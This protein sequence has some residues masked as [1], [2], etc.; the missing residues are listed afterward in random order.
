MVKRS[1]MNF[2]LSLGVKTSRGRRE[3]GVSQLAG[4]QGNP[5]TQ[6]LTPDSQGISQENLYSQ[7]NHLRQGAHHVQGGELGV[8]KELCRWRVMAFPPQ[9]LLSLECCIRNEDAPSH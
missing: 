2:W 9:L 6:P 8:A 1:D 7:K 5:S 3:T 4:L